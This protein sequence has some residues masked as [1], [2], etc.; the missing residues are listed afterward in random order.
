MIYDPD[1]CFLSRCPEIGFKQK[2]KKLSLQLELD[3]DF[4]VILWCRRLCD[5]ATFLVDRNNKELVD[6]IVASDYLAFVRK[7]LRLAAVS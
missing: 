3:V 2:Q 1:Y 5:V 4:D 7:P 6:L